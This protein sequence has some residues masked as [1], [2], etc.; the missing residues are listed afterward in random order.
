[1]QPVDENCGDFMLVGTLKDV[2]YSYLQ[3]IIIIDNYNCDENLNYLINKILIEEF[4]QNYKT[5]LRF[6]H[7]NKNKYLFK[8]K[9]FYAFIENNNL[10][11]KEEINNIIDNN[12]L[13]LNEIYQRYCL[14]DKKIEK[15]IFIYTKKIRQKY[16]KLKNNDIEISLEKQLKNENSTTIETEK[17]I[18]TSNTN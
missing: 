1:M 18:N 3:V 7:Q 5:N 4:P 17:K 15:P 14:N 6:I 13:T 8:D 9:I 10:V 16:I 11:L 12:K 2:G